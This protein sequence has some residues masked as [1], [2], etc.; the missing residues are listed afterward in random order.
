MEELCTFFIC[1]KSLL[2]FPHKRNAETATDHAV[3]GSEVNKSGMFGLTTSEEFVA[4]SHKARVRCLCRTN[5]I[6]GCVFI[7]T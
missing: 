6:Y 2:R 7:V 4:V 1:G 3:G 5:G